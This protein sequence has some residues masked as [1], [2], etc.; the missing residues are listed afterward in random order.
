MGDP[1]GEEKGGRGSGKIRRVQAGR[2]KEIPH[3]IE[4]HQDHHGP[5]NDVDG[6]EPDAPY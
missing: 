3:V 4:R 6:F 1:P 2:A 5:A